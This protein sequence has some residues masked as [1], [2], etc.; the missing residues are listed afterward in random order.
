MIQLSIPNRL[1]PHSH[2]ILLN[3]HFS[4][5]KLVI[6]PAGEAAV[7]EAVEVT[8]TKLVTAAIVLTLAVAVVVAE[9]EN[10]GSISS[11]H[12]RK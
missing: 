1:F 2:Y 4:L 3:L 9:E 5:Q 10:G 7:E 12:R 11:N 8:V 6:V